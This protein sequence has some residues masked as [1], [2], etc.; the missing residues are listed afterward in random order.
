M[1][2]AK[3]R[4]SGRRRIHSTLQRTNY[5]KKN[6][7][8]T[9][10][11]DPDYSPIQRC[12]PPRTHETAPPTTRPCDSCGVCKTT[13]W[14]T[15][16]VRDLNLGFLR[17]LAPACEAF[18][19]SSHLSDWISFRECTLLRSMKISLFKCAMRVDFVLRKGNTVP[20]V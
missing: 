5:E 12:T 7:I 11:E 3:K 10:E 9:Q 18:F 20:F 4:S 13:M 17:L 15:Y 14:R 1:G 6:G 16:K 19:F 2:S 8:S